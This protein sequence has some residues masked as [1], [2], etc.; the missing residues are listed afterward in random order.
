MIRIG[1]N[2]LVSAVLLLLAS[3]TVWER[4][5]GTFLDYP[6]LL[7]SN[8]Q[9]VEDISLSE[10]ERSAQLEQLRKFATEPYPE[11]KINAGDVF[12]IKV[13]NHPDLELQT[14]ITPDGYIAMM[15][16]GQVKVAGCTLPE[17]IKKI[18][19]ALSD[20]IKTPVVS[21]APTLINS[22]NVTIA[23]GVN[24]PGRY[25][26]SD[27]MRLSD[28]FAMAGG[29]ASRLFDGQVVDVAD[30]KN[31]VF[32]RDNKNVPVDF[33]AAIERGDHWNNIKLHRDDYIYVAVRSETMVTLLGEVYNPHRRIW[34]QT[35]GLLEIISEGGGLKETYWKYAVIMRGSVT[36]PTYYRADLD[37][38]LLGKKPNIM[39]NPGDIVYV[40]RDNISEY[41]VFIRKLMPTGQLINLFL[42]P[43]F[44]WMRF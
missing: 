25:S 15:F 30:F 31:S 18:E 6:E 40:P 35:L 36:N 4:G 37:G 34:N 2:I 9:V 3:C 20:Y 41:N 27:G 14:P 28:L 17:A 39:L 24:R 10:E 22:Q 23:G 44:F 26:V 19:T 8:P 11:Y 1:R 29:S 32:V 13:Y 42:T 21:M 16:V 43:G 33:S 38:I 12:Q 7:E 5:T